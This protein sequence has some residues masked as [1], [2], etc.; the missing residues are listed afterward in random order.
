[1][2]GLALISLVT[3]AIVGA[4]WG[5]PPSSVIFPTQREPLTFSHRQH[6]ALGAACLDCHAAAETS[7]SAVDSL[8]PGEAACRSCHA[9]DRAQPTEAGCGSCHVGFVVGEPPAR[10]HVPPPSLKFDHAAHVSRGQACSGCHGTLEDADLAGRDALPTMTLCLQCHDDEA[11]PSAC[12]TCH[13]TDLGVLRTELPAGDL[14]PSGQIYGDAHDLAFVRDHGPAASRDADYCGSCHQDSDCLE[15][16][17]GVR[18]P[19][20]FHPADYVLIHAIDGR[21]NDPD[22]STCHREQTFCVGCHQRSGIAGG[23]TGDFDQQQPGR[24][25]HP[26]DW[27]SDGHAREARA[28]LDTCVSCHRE[29]D[30]LECHTSEPGSPQVSP[31]G[32]GW[33]NSARCEALAARNPRMC[34]R[35]HIDESELGCDF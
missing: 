10:L 13:L 31:H 14:V 3:A 34:T 19:D 23:D 27:A 26:A 25:F 16:H 6:L 2:R 32:P 7:R 9:I 12:A 21:R 1:M 11:A 20:D 33:R 35:C 15:C 18:R 30:C 17:A 8:M 28:N 22:C 24:Q 4:A 5:G 29:D